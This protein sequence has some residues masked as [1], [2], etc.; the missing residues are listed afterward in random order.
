MDKNPEKLRNK[1]GQLEKNYQNRKKTQ[2]E[3]QETTNKDRI[4]NI[5]VEQ[6]PIC[7]MDVGNHTGGA[8]QK[9]L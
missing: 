2:T 5:H 9:N 7:N 8:S 6:I 3:L 4:S 1:E